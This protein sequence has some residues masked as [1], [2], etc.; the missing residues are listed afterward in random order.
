MALADT[1]KAFDTL[2]VYAEGI[3]KVVLF[4]EGA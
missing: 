4:P 2:E 3:G 1:Q